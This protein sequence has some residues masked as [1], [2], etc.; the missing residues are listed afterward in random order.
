MNPWLLLIHQIPAK[1]GYLRVKV[2]RRLQ[3]VGAVAVKSSVYALPANDQSLEDFQWLRS[4]ILEGGGDAA[5]FGAT[6]VEGLSDAALQG[7]FNAARDADYAA[8]VEEAREL[9]ART[10]G[11][12]PSG[13]AELSRLHERLSGIEAM[14]WYGAPGRGAALAELAAIE[15][16]VRSSRENAEEEVAPRPRGGTWVTRRGVK[17]DRMA[18]AWL[19]RRCIDPDATFRFVSDAADA[20]KG[21]LRFDMYE[22]EFT[23]EGDRCTFEVLLRRFALDGPALHGIAEVIHDLDLKDGKYSRPETAGVG[24]LLTGIAL[25]HH[26]DDDRIAA[27]TSAL[28]ALRACLEAARD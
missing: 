6:C 16:A 21:E 18:S 1:P 23:H 24:A 28:D 9:R 8:V 19:I 15:V 26:D 10:E 7:L 13:L 27:A 3:Q 5:V 12:S 22:G 11:V 25:T 4:E 20:R 17:V 14:D 2:G